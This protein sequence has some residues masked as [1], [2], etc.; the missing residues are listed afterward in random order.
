MRPILGHNLT[1][2]TLGVFILWMGWFG[3]NPGSTAAIAT[4]EAQNTASLVFMNTN[5]AAATGA[6]ASLLLAWWRYGKPSLSLSLNGVLAG[7]VGTTAV[8]TPFRRS[9]QR[10]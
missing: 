6:L 10:V 2:A 7:L 5:I 4:E 1:I 9:V 8:A 3:F